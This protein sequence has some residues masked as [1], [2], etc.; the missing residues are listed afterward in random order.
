MDA[1]GIRDRIKLIIHC[2]ADNS[3]LKSIGTAG[4]W[5]GTGVTVIQTWN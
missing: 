1:E 4:H 5:V 3:S 2:R